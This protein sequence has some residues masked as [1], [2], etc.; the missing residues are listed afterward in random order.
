[1]PNTNKRRQHNANDACTKAMQHYEAALRCL[2]DAD[3]PA[4][5]LEAL[6]FAEVFLERA[7][8]D[9]VRRGLVA[10]VSLRAG[11]PARGNG[12]DQRHAHF[13]LFSGRQQRRGAAAARLAWRCGDD[14]AAC[15]GMERARAAAADDEES[16][17]RGGAARPVPRGA[18]PG[19]RGPRIG[20]ARLRPGPFPGRR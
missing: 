12:S 2:A 7:Q 4:V 8:D 3:E 6:D 14:E 16:R 17:R 1:M 9:D 13:E 15:E 11:R 20:G 19:P 5:A 10:E 18:R